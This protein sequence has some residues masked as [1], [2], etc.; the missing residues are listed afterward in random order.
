[1][2]DGGSDSLEADLRD[3]GGKKKK[4]EKMVRGRNTLLLLFLLCGEGGIYGLA[5]ILP[6][7]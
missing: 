6:M 4:C 3:A 2:E 5:L 7:A 1:M